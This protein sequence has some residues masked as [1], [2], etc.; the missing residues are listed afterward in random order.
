MKYDTVAS[1]ESIQKVTEGLKTR[2]FTPH[3]AGSKSEALELI[4]TLIPKGASVMNGSSRT[5]EEIGFVDYLKEGAHEWNNLHA[6]VLK[7]EDKTKQAT[8]RKQALLS[9]YYLGSV[10]AITEGGE[11]VIASN[12][13]SQL[14]HLVYTSPN[15][16]LVVGTQ[17]ITPSLEEGLKRLETYVVP[18]EDVN[19]QQKYGVHTKKNKTLI[20]HGESTMTSRNAHVILVTEKLGF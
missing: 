5:L 8:L 13:G 4:K 16:I 15:L 3:V 20:L 9:D 10:H 1:K 7:E 19:M 17:K 2:G 6:N 14:P 11:M 12:T 18:L